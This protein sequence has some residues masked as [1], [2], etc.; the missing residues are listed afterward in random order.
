MTL[1]IRSGGEGVG[2]YIFNVGVLN[3]NNFSIC[4]H[5]GSIRRNSPR[6]PKGSRGATLPVP[7][8]SET[9]PAVLLVLSLFRF[10]IPALDVASRRDY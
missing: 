2:G 3:L 4:S 9:L 7:R 1:F 10:I 5:R 6:G 8:L